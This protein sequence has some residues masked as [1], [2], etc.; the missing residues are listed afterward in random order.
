[1]EDVVDIGIDHH[2]ALETAAEVYAA[3][4]LYGNRHPGNACDGKKNM[5]SESRGAFELVDE[6]LRRAADELPADKRK[7]FVL[8]NLKEG[9]VLR[10][11]PK[12]VKERIVGWV[13][14]AKVN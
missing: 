6:F 11:L 10:H 3:I 12:D 7:G 9:D 5:T 4:G 2:G 14:T 8:D 1:V 13:D